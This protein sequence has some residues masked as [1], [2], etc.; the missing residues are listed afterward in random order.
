MLARMCSCVTKL[1]QNIKQNGYEPEVSFL[2]RFRFRFGL[3]FSE[4]SD[5]DD[6]WNLNRISRD[7][8]VFVGLPLIISS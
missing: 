8:N 2:K 4:P 5:Y 6:L 3:G 1:R 7:L